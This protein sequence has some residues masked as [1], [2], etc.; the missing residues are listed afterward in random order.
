MTRKNEITA[1]APRQTDC[2]IENLS[3]V[4]LAHVYVAFINGCAGARIKK[5]LRREHR[6]RKEIGVRIKMHGRINTTTGRANSCVNIFVFTYQGLK[7]LTWQFR[8]KQRNT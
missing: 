6:V 3:F 5:Y 1:R 2:N 8:I 7:L 4:Y